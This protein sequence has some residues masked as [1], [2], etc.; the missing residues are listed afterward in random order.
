MDFYTI[1]FLYTIN[2]TN[3]GAGCGQAFAMDSTCLHSTDGN[4]HWQC[5]RGEIPRHINPKKSIQSIIPACTLPGYAGGFIDR[6]IFILNRLLYLQDMS[7]NARL[8]LL[9]HFIT[10]QRQVSFHL[11]EFL[12]SIFMGSGLSGLRR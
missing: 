8:L 10:P 5:H 9:L 11:V 7:P 3:E 1:Q 12:L 6:R 4:L 2:V